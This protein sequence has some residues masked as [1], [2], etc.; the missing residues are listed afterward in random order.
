MRSTSFFK[1]CPVCGGR[2]QLAGGSH[3]HPT[4]I[5]CG[6][7]LYQNAKPTAS[8]I[9]IN[10]RGEILLVRRAV[11]PRK[12]YWDA[13]GGFL[14]EWE[15]PEAGARREL[16]E[17]LGVRLKRLRLLGVYMDSYRQ[18]YIAATLNVIYL[19]EIAGGRLVPADDVADYRWFALNRI[20]ASRL[21][22]PWIRQALEDIL[23]NRSSI[24]YM[25]KK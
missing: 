10:V 11:S 14:E 22:F 9:P 20:P 3:S 15:S 17:E 13:P 2:T 6:F 19:A 1:F 21:A 16:R 4:C 18:R 12:G 8:A 23:K 7:V 25:M 5:V 24:K